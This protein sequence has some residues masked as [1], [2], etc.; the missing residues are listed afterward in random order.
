[1]QNTQFEK[2]LGL[3]LEKKMRLYSESGDFAVDIKKTYTM[4]E[5]GKIVEWQKNSKKIKLLAIKALLKIGEIEKA[6]MNLVK[7][8]HNS[9]GGSNLIISTEHIGMLMRH[10]YL[11]CL[12]DI[13][14]KRIETREKVTLLLEL[15][16]EK[17][18]DKVGKI[19]IIIE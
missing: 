12:I 2:K 5:Y 7:L 14:T 10:V 19:S 18:S 15:V 1:L 4:K 8:E 11:K 3:S 17:A 6:D 16:K 13:R 9:N